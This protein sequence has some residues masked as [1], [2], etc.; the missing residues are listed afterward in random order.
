VISREI[1]IL[2]LAEERCPDEK[3]DIV[4]RRNIIANSNEYR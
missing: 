1:W 3:I 4:T 2:P